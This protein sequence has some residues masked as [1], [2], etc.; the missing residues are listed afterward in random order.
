MTDTDEDVTVYK[1]I[2]LGDPAVGKSA[3]YRRYAVDTSFSCGARCT[4]GI[5]FAVRHILINNK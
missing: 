3:L 1:I 5:D 2:M 4:I